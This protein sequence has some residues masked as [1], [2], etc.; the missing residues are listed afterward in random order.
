MAN[1]YDV[2]TW[3]VPGNS[4]ITA[5]TDIGAVIN[6]IIADIKSR[7]TDPTA[8]PGG[9]IY[10]PPGDYSLK[11][12]VT[13]D[14]SYLIIKGSGHGFT[15]QSIRYNSNTAGWYE[16][17]PGGSHI[18]V[19]NTDGNGEAFLVTRG[20]NPRLS[21]VVFRD[22]CI[23]GVSFTP[24]Q[25][26]YTNGKTGIRVAT[27]ND[28]FLVEAM[29]FT[30]LEHGLIIDNNDALSVTNNYFTENGNC[31][32][33][34]TAGFASKITNNL[35]GA[36]PAGYSIFAE[37]QFG[38]LISSNNVFPRGQSLVHLKNTSK[39]SITGNRFHAFYPGAITC[40]GLNKENLISSN[41]FY[42]ESETYAPFQG[43][44]NGRDD[45][46]GMI[47]L[48][49]DNNMVSGNLFDYFVDS[50]KVVP[51]GGTP[52]IIL[53]KGGDSNRISDNHVVANMFVHNVVLDG[54]TTATKIL[55]SGAAATIQALTTNYTLRPTP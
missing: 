38:L 54:S 44:T 16:L 43:V 19:Q 48:L 41:H 6:S 10:I 24:T 4:S 31:I 47:F 49:G 17:A 13:I 3:T 2:T 21:S 50:T 23:D 8:K 5:A 46:F 27:G 12:R 18:K 35:I 39:S 26:S 36:G 45:L 1:V 52:T 14:I 32:Q 51:A 11:T 20:G 28:S 37:G 29:C 55:D 34:T 22:F 42:R 33:L 25:N 53:V 15:S 30:Y 9:V 7:Q 40:E